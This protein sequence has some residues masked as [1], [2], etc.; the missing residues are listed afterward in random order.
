MLLARGEKL[1][2]RAIEVL[3]RLLVRQMAYTLERYQASIAEIPAQR[4]GGVERDGAVSRPP[5]EQRGVIAY[6]GQRALQ[7]REVGRPI[8]YDVRSMAEDM[9]LDDRYPIAF[10]RIGRDLCSVAEHAAQPQVVEHAPALHRVA[11]QE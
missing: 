1:D 11:E 3:G 10:Q 8:P 5:D 2:E 6:L 9:V 7:F 4:F